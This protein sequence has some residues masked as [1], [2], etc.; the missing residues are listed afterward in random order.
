[1]RNQSPLYNVGRISTRVYPDH[2]GPARHV[3][4]LSKA[5]NRLRISNVTIST[6]PRNRFRS[7]RNEKLVLLPVKSPTQN[8][9]AFL[10]AIFSLAYFLFA[11]L[12]SVFVFAKRRVDIIHAHSP[13]LSGLVGVLVSKALRKPFIY[14]VHGLAGPS[15]KW[16]ESGGSILQLGLEIFVLNNADAIITVAS[17]YAEF[18]QKINP[19]LRIAVIGNGVNTKEF[20][21]LMNDDGISAKR[22]ELGIPFNQQLILWAGNF[23]FNEKT[24]GVIDTLNALKEV[25]EAQSN[26]ALV[27]VGEGESENDVINHAASLEFADRVHFLGYRSDVKEIMQASDLFVLVSHHEGSPNALLESMAVGLPCIGSNVGGVP[28]IVRDAGYLIKP[29]DTKSLAK[30]L[31]QLLKHGD[32]RKQV[33]QLCRHKAVA[34]L[35]WESIAAKTIFVYNEALV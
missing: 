5:L 13:A 12:F 1:M 25:N 6:T 14:T 4:E 7:K 23:S 17:D 34:H 30:R 19:A 32:L 11:L 28:E 18:V 8:S 22:L 2:G 3:Y 15:F 10:Q 21:P 24:R 35:S 31:I 16:S 33:S 27:L 26:W 29:G 20:A 9:G